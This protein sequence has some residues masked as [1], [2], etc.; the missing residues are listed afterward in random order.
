MTALLIACLV[1]AP[2]QAPAATTTR[3]PSRPAL[4]AKA[5]VPGHSIRGVASWGCC[6]PAVVTRLPRG[7]RITVCGRLGC[8][9]G[10]SVGY[11]PAKRTHRIAD[12]SPAVFER[13]CGSLAAGLCEVVL[14][15]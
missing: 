8:W 15:W 13:I 10:R 5:P 12:L 14:S 6:W 11:G 2:L 9:S 3:E 4:R 7:T 1:L